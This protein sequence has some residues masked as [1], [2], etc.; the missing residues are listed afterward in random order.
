MKVRYTNV[1]LGMNEM[2]D[3]AVRGALVFQRAC[4]LNRVFKNM[5]V[6]S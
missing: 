1:Q 5:K 3:R 4:G 2:M 6:G